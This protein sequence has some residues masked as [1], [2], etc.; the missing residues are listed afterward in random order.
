[1]LWLCVLSQGMQWHIHFDSGISTS[2]V[3]SPLSQRNE[4]YICEDLVLWCWAHRCE[5]GAWHLF[6]LTVPTLLGTAREPTTE[7][8]CALMA[9]LE[10]DNHWERWKGSK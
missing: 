4:Q 2:D 5:N 3:I 7:N 8:A 9:L 6:G 1:M 10:F